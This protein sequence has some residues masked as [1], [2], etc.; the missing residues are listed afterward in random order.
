[1]NKPTA[2]SSYALFLFRWI[3][4]HSLVWGAIYYLGFDMFHRGEINSWGDAF[5]QSVSLIPV[6]LLFG[7]GLG[8]VQGILLR[9]SLAKSRKWFSVTLISH[10][11]GL[12]GGLILSVGQIWLVAKLFTGWD[13]LGLND[14]LS[15]FFPVQ[16]LMLVN[17]LIVGFAQARWGFRTSYARSGDRWLWGLGNGLAWFAGSSANGMIRMPVISS[18]VAGAVLGLIT[19]VFLVMIFGQAPST[20]VYPPARAKG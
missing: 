10:S 17:G 18:L 16:Q 15:I 9:N 8:I 19:G 12:T 6:G 1:M 2:L 11:F 5:A 4:V 3:I 7:V 14:S 20:P 13:V